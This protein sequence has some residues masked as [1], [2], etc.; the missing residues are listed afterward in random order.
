[1]CAKVMS[2]SLFGSVFAIERERGE[3][4]D[5]DGREYMIHNIINSLYIYVQ[6]YMSLEESEAHT[7]VRHIMNRFDSHCAIFHLYRCRCAGEL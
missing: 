7:I 4:I 6:P 1:M 5:G 2:V 3:N